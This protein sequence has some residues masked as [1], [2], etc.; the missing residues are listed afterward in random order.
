MKLIK[1]IAGSFL[2][3]LMPG[4]A[5]R[6]GTNAASDIN[7][8]MV[9]SSVVKSSDAGYV[10]KATT[11]KSMK[12]MVAIK[13]KNKIAEPLWLTLTLINLRTNAAT[14]NERNKFIEC[15]IKVFDSNGKLCD[16]TKQGYQ[17]LGGDENEAAWNTYI[18]LDPGASHVWKYDLMELFVL[19]PGVYTVSAKH[20]PLSL[21]DPTY[22]RLSV[23]GV[24]FRITE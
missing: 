21:E 22:V 5:N 3:L 20:A 10:T 4:C 17:L 15:G 14:W 11:A 13:A 7:G 19:K 1:Y 16:Y 18:K 23:N 8:G 2:L 9:K 6:N 24:K 12:L